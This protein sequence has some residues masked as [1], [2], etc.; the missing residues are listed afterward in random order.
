M[1]SVLALASSGRC[2][3]VLSTW[4]ALFILSFGFPGAGASKRRPGA[5]PGQILQRDAGSIPAARFGAGMVWF[6]GQVL[7][8][9]GVTNGGEQRVAQHHWGDLVIHLGHTG[10]LLIFLFL[11]L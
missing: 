9:G 4:S 5:F 10:S 1:L 6:E 3:A 11:E 2:V 8:F 7:V